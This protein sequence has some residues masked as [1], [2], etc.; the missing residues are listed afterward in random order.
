MKVTSLNNDSDYNDE[1]EFSV[2]ENNEIRELVIPNELAGMRLDAALAKLLPDFSRSRMTSWI[3]DDQVLLNGKPCEPKQKLIGQEKLTIT[4]V[5]SDENLAFTP[6]DIALDVIYEDDTVIVLNKSADMV[7]HPASGNWTGTILNGLLYHYPEL[8]QIPRAGIVHRLD[9]DTSGLMV[10]A[11]TLQAQNNLVQQLQNRTVKRIYRAVCDGIVPFDGIIETKIGRDPHN[12]VKMAVVKFGGKE[13]ITH[14]KVLERYTTHSYVECSLETGRTHQIRVHMREA[15]HPL[16]GDPVYG[17]PRYKC[18][19]EVKDSIKKLHRQ[20]LHAYR[21]S[22]IHPVSKEEVSFEAKLPEDIYQ[23]LSV[24][25]L[26]S[27]LDS[28]LTH[29]DAY[30]QSMDSEDDDD[31][32]DGDVEVIYVKD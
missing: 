2:K 19:D 8:Q 16:A 28:S 27:G 5:P 4:I 26:E 11:R 17:N 12:R 3:K 23:L 29:E 10:V 9:K 24:L 7:V 25:R 6:E 30:Q 18:S 15:R 20:A 14:V 31:W 22:F 1:F 21:L 13:A 32:D